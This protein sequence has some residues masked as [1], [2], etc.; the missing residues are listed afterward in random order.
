MSA[1][2]SSLEVPPPPVHRSGDLA[3]PYSVDLRGA[4][5]RAWAAMTRRRRSWTGIL[6][7]GYQLPRSWKK[8]RAASAAPWARP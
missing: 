3:L 5:R 2:V 1:A 4:L 7:V 6:R 8:D